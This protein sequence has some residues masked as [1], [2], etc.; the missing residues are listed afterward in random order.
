MKSPIKSSATCA[1]SNPCLFD[2]RNSSGERIGHG[3][4]NPQRCIRAQERGR[5]AEQIP[6]PSRKER[7]PA[8]I[9]IQGP[10]H[11]RFTG[12]RDIRSTREVE[13]T[14]LLES[15]PTG[16]ESIA[17][18]IPTRGLSETWTSYIESGRRGRAQLVSGIQLRR[19]RDVG[20][21]KIEKDASLGRVAE[22]YRCDSEKA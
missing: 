2:D 12:R 6:R 9:R 10:C 7:R 3:S 8:I 1:R 20:H 5:P 22:S 17:G 16:V 14:P 18:Q 15:A 21:G 13:S 11:P 19:E 4:K